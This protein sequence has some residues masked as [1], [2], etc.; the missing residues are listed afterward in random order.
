MISSDL[1][2]SVIIATN[3]RDCVL[4]ETLQHMLRLDRSGINVEFIIVD[5]NSADK[6]KDVVMDFSERLPL[7]YL[8]ESKPGQNCARNRALAQSQLG[9]IVAFTDD[10]VE[11]E[12]NWLQ[13]I[14]S[15][16]R[17]QPDYSIFGGKIYPIWPEVSLPRWTKN[18]FIQQFGFAAYEYAD[19]ECLYARN[20]YPSSANF[21]IRRELVTNGKRFDESIAW[22]PKNRIMATETTFLRGL[23]QDGYRMFYSPESVVGHKIAVEQLSLRYLIKRA[24]SWG[25]GMAHIRPLCRRALLDRHPSLWRWIRI[26]AIVRLTLNMAAS[27]VPTVLKK[28]QKSIQAMQW[29]GYNIESMRIAKGENSL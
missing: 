29:I 16:S 17:R 26:G 28:P 9:E 15:V 20:Q 4:R 1:D 12:E 6:T 11:P 3:N 5:N 18:H 24:Y 19:S 13:T 21:W 22:H 25:R 8:F 2:I 7:R 14:M 23:S 27:V 10:D